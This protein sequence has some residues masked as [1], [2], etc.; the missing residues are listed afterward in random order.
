MGCEVDNLSWMVVINTCTCSMPDLFSCSFSKHSLV[1]R[2]GCSQD[3]KARG[4]IKLLRNQVD[5]QNFSLQCNVSIFIYVTYLEIVCGL[6]AG[7]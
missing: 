1:N 5:I 4:F 6:N 7:V 3:K 2:S